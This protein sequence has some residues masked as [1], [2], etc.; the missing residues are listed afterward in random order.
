MDAANNLP[1]LGAGSTSTTDRPPLKQVHTHSARDLRGDAD[2]TD[3]EEGKISTS[4]LSRSPTVSPTESP[5]RLRSWRSFILGRTW[6]PDL[7]IEAI[8]DALPAV[9]LTLALGALLCAVVVLSRPKS[10]TSGR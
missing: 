6:M 1:V 5:S 4:P 2:T 8:E 7:S 10:S 3:D 9:A